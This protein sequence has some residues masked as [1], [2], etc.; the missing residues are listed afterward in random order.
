MAE[1]WQMLDAGFPSL[2][3]GVP[4]L[5]QVQNLHSYLFQMKRNLQMTLQAMDKENRLLKEQVTELKKK[6]EILENTSRGSDRNEGG[7]V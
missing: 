4:L 2:E 3:R 7:V 5:Q 1:G 6:I